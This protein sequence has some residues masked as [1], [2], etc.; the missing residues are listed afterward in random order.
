MDISEDAVGPIAL[1][2]HDA[3][4]MPDAR[5][6][7][8]ML[9]FFEIPWR[10]LTAGEIRDGSFARFLEGHSR[11]A[12]LASAKSLAALLQ[13]G[14][15]RLA[16][17]CGPA[18]SVYVYGWEPT[19]ACRALLREIAGDGDA[20][21]RPRAEHNSSVS[22]AGDFV[23]MCGSLSGISFALDPG[24]AQ[25]V[26]AMRPGDRQFQAI[27][28]VPQGQ[29]F[30]SLVYE[31]V[32]F[33]VDA[34]SA[35]LDIHQ[36][37]TRRFDVRQNFSGA[38]AA[39]LYLKWAFRDIWWEAPELNACLIVDDLLLRQRHG[40]FL[41]DDLLRLVDQHGI[42]ATVAF[43]PWN[44]RRRDERVVEVLRRKAE[45]LSVCMHGCDHSRDE[46]AV[47]SAAW[48]DG[49]V[50]TAQQRMSKL[51]AQTQLAHDE[52]QV[53]PQGKFCPEASV[54]LKQNGLVAAVNTEPAPYDQALNR[55]TV[56]DQWSTANLCYGGFPIFSRRNIGDGVENFAF[57]GFLGKP[58]LIGGHHDL[59]Q[60]SCEE[61]IG[62]LKKLHSLEWELRWRTLGNAL[63]RS[64]KF[65]EAGGVSL[66]KMY[67]EQLVLVNSSDA[68]KTF[69]IAKRMDDIAGLEGVAIDSQP[70]GYELADGQ[71]RFTVE[72]PPRS[73]ITARCE[74]TGQA[75]H[76][77]PDPFSY[78]AKI[79]VVRHLTVL[80]DSFQSR[81][82]L[83]N[84]SVMLAM[85]L[86]EYLP[87]RRN[88]SVHLG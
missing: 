17:V 16:D 57:D 28:S 62:F 78:R 55:T 33:F 51:F 36:P 37:S 63:P 45:S 39:V 71:I 64:C 43:I 73:A 34:S 53:F 18:A 80:R 11:Y 32:R 9:D 30:A 86:R 40:Y 50:K 21:I 60:G 81:A 46:F 3:P 87:P 75:P 76:Y 47:R 79:A 23:E 48:L 74:Y 82:G 35:I 20:D 26:L 22:I 10:S 25:T 85:K 29:L 65:R 52:V 8:A 24:A 27:A 7:Q 4:D 58:C 5:H 84:R 12:V 6:L 14:K 41:Y 77:L 88:P 66:V 15:S 59:F 19:A 38:V 54:A 68:A 70:A 56:A 1:L 31:G 13:P 42:A 69:T 2:L 72:A 83:M 61:L 44:W 49:K 67:A